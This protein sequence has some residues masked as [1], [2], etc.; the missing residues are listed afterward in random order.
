[1]ELLFRSRVHSVELLFRSGVHFV[2]LQFHSDVDCV[3]LLFRSKVHSVELLIRFQVHP[4][5]L[6]LHFGAHFGARS[7]ALLRL[8]YIS[9]A[10]G[11]LQGATDRNKK[12]LPAVDIALR[13]SI[14]CGG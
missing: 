1:M 12:P 4:A 14:H 8:V 6:L 7:A 10:Q 5:E 13:C 11:L 2:E 9:F 3:E